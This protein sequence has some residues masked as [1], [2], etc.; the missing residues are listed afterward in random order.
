M[1]SAKVRNTEHTIY[2]DGSIISANGKRL[3]TWVGT[4]GYE[5]FRVCT[6]GKKYA[7]RLHRILGECFIPNPD[8]LPFIKH[9][10]D[11]KTDNRLENLEWGTNSEN[12]KEGYSNNCYQFPSKNNYPVRA[13]NII[14]GDVVIETSIRALS[15]AIKENRKKISAILKGKRTNK[16]DWVFEWIIED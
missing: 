5:L 10:N 3:T 8:N 14:T 6:G 12:V 4:Q 7:Y 15:E 16:T 2:E 13:T 11:I 9:K 1:R